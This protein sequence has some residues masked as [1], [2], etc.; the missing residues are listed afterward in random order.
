[1]DIPDEFILAADDSVYVCGT[2]AAFNRY[3]EEY[4]QSQP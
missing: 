1:M 3:Y 4:P 2:A